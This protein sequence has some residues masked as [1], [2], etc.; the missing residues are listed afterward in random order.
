MSQTIIP[1]QWSGDSYSTVGDVFSNPS[2]AAVVKLS[3]Q[4]TPTLLNETA[5]NVNGNTISV[6][7]T[8]IYQQPAG[9]TASSYFPGNNA[10]NRLPQIG[11]GGGWSRTNSS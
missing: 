1:T 2:W 7:P 9:W 10:L 4:L 5:F 8:G 6:T 3:Q 11:F